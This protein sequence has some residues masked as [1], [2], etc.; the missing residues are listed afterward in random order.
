MLQNVTQTFKNEWPSNLIMEDI[1]QSCQ[2]YVVLAQDQEL[3]LSGTEELWLLSANHRRMHSATRHLKN[4]KF[5]SMGCFSG[6]FLMPQWEMPMK[7]HWGPQFPH[8]EV[9]PQH[10]RILRIHPRLSKPTL[11]QLVRN[12]MSG[13]L[14][15][16]AELIRSGS[17]HRTHP[18]QT[19]PD[20]RHQQ[21][22]FKHNSAI[23][24]GMEVRE[25]G[26]L[27]VS[28][29]QLCTHKHRPGAKIK[30]KALCQTGSELL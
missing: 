12:L 24:R 16:L 11:A 10:N 4:R 28:M 19:D 29:D 20:A 18:M 17:I 6:S 5:R 23:T 2:H 9:C 3:A 1:S 8:T 7:S 15:L 26:E 14:D 13:L 30:A 22:A 21:R 27:H 25:A